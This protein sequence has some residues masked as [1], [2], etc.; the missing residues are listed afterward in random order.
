V[1]TARHGRSRSGNSIGCVLGLRRLRYFLTVAEDR[2]FTRAAERLHVAQPAL[3]RQLRLLEQDLGV[4]LMQRTTH[5]F[6]LTDAGR[7]LVEHGQPLLDQATTLDSALRSFGA[8]SS[9]RVV[10]GYGTSAGYET[11][12]RL[13]AAIGSDL[14]GLEIITHVMATDAIV[15]GL[16]NGTIDVGVVRCPPDAPGIESQL[17]RLEPQGVLVPET[18]PL[19]GCAEVALE[20]LRQEPVLLHPRAANPGHY[21]AV[22]ELLQSAGIE[23]RV[24]VRDVSV[25]LQHT[26]VL[27]GRAVAIVGESTR[28]S[29]PPRLSWIPFCPPVTLEVRLLART[30]NRP[31]AVNGFLA[32]AET[33][34]DALGWRGSVIRRAG[35]EFSP[36][37]S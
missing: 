16:E 2:N 24:E 7:Y 19:A 10:V 35:G 18:H 12:P 11:A 29:L 1:R 37:P 9:G 33:I 6:E 36:P 15:A 17:L 23:P 26:P 31:P 32:A 28:V 22:V 13:L 3:S 25:D 34:A 4:E 8:G 27:E 14:P 5:T 30:L 21:D 20:A